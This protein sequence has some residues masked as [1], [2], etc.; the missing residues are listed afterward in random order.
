MDVSV[1][2]PP[3][4]ERNTLRAAPRRA[5]AVAPVGEANGDRVAQAGAF[6]AARARGD[7][8]HALHPK[9]VLVREVRQL[10][11]EAGAGELRLAHQQTRG[12]RREGFEVPR[13]I[14]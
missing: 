4:L 14:G 6:A 9:A 10:E 12:I 3:P 1:L 5:I 7:D 13:G 2:L 11:I 8:V